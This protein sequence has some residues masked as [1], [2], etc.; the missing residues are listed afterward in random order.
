MDNVSRCQY[1][2]PRKQ[3]RC[4]MLVKSGQLYCGEHSYISNPES[5]IPCPLD[6]AHSVHVENLDDHLQRCNQS[7]NANQPWFKRD[8]NLFDLSD[9]SECFGKVNV[10]VNTLRKVIKFYEQLQLDIPVEFIP[11]AKLEAMSL[12]KFGST[13]EKCKRDRDQVSSILGHL[14][15]LNLLESDESVSFLEFGAGR[16]KLTYWLSTIFHQQGDDARHRYV[17]IEQ[18]GTRYKYE[19]KAVADGQRRDCFTRIRCGIEHVML[20]CIYQLKITKYTVAICK[21]LCGSAFDAALVSVVNSLSDPAVQI[22]A[23]IMAP[24]CHHRCK[25]SQFCGKEL[26]TFFNFEADQFAE[27][28]RIISWSTCGFSSLEDKICTIK[29]SSCSE[30][31]SACGNC[32]T[33]NREEVGHKAKVLL[34]WARAAYLQRFGF[35][36]RLVQFVP[37]QTSPENLLLIGVRE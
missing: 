6:P 1:I 13:G 34:N 27:L 24:C 16:A 11:Y 5:R 15:A 25:W 28:R 2:V 3:R 17:L 8:V 37:L 35:S 12:E 18:S 10:S 29:C 9:K 26:F 19:N 31:D 32:F 23:L 14:N 20:N 36:V 30:V 22:K 33:V 4:R 7:K 21:H